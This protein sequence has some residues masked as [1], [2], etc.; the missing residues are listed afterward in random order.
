MF[1]FFL[2]LK[3]LMVIL[4]YYFSSTKRYINLLIA[5]FKYRPKTILE[6]GVFN[7]VRSKQLIECAKI[8]NRK[9]IFYGFDLFD[10][11]IGDKNL[12]KYEAS[13]FPLTKKNIKQK[14]LK[15]NDK[16]FLFQGFSKTTLKKFLRKK[17]KIDFIFIDGGHSVDTIRSDWKYVKQMMDDKS[18]VIFDDYY[19]GIKNKIK[20]IGCNVVINKIDRKKFA[21]KKLPFIDY[22]EKNKNRLG[23]QMVLVKKNVNHL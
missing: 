13:K 22:F 5:I 16:N 17:K 14:L 10:I 19:Y 23:I 7:G 3:S 20:E 12:K 1:K 15:I 21:V 4:Q 9:I 18:I 11:M 6:I 8:F 2:L